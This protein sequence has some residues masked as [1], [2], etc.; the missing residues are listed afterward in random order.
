MSHLQNF[1]SH[2]LPD[3]LP[4]EVG[5]RHGF[6]PLT[7]HD[8]AV[9]DEAHYRHYEEHKHCTHQ[10]HLVKSTDGHHIGWD[11]GHP[12]VSQVL[13]YQPATKNIMEDF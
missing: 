9:A 10:H 5:G 13:F 7:L 3:A 8:P 2:C 4:A 1:G 12:R 11:I 6:L